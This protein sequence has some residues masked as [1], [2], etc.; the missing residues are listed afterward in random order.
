MASIRKFDDEHIKLIKTF[1]PKERGVKRVHLK[2]TLNGIL[3]VLQNGGRWK[4][5]PKRYGKYK[6][7]YNMFRRYSLNGVWNRIHDFLVSWKAEMGVSMLD[8]SFAGAHRTSASL[9][10]GVGSERA[11]GKSK[12]GW[13]TKIQ[14]YADAMG[15]PVAFHLTGGNVS[16]YVGYEML[17]DMADGRVEHLIGDR[18]YDSNK[19]RSGLEERGIQ[20][21]I[22]GRRNR[23]TEIEYDK[24]LYKTRH[25]I[26]NAFAKL[27]DWRHIAMRHHRCPKIFLGV[28]VL[29]TIVK[30]WL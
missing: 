14:T 2:K 11:I 12:G 6:T 27:K 16:D 23:K 1:L 7:A 20:P 9:A 10:V 28:I 3:H 26:E 21:C 4:D 15:R 22:P 24:E 25:R 17:P 30:F 13:T 5:M 29:A 19:I 8:A 18:G